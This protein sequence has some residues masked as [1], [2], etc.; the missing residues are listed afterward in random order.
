[1]IEDDDIE[2]KK[3]IDT[4]DRLF[5]YFIPI[6]GLVVIVSA[7]WNMMSAKE[8]AAKAPEPISFQYM[9]DG[10]MCYS[11]MTYQDRPVS[12]VLVDC[13]LLDADEE[14]THLSV[15]PKIKI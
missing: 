12:H 5:G 4:R 11:I 7:S 3:P 10:G 9:N 14:G 8:A 2:D 13:S 15:S 6:C 1:M